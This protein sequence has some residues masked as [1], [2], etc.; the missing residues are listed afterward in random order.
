MYLLDDRERSY[1]QVWP[2]AALPLLEPAKEGGGL[3]GLAHALQSG[4]FG[5]AK[6]RKNTTEKGLLALTISSASSAFCLPS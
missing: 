5:L 3:G 1:D 4:G 2:G 6:T